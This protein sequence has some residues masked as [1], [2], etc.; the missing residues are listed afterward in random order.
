[1]FKNVAVNSATYFE[2]ILKHQASD[3][4]PLVSLGES[5][6][7]GVITLVERNSYTSVF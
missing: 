4:K 5:Y 2:T 1:M 3:S 6:L 7:F